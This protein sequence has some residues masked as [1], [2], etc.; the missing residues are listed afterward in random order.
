MKRINLLDASLEELN[1][2]RASVDREW[3]DLNDRILNTNSLS[4]EIDTMI[5]RVEQL[6]E[7]SGLLTLAIESFNDVHTSGTPGQDGGWYW[8]GESSTIDF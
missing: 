4:P 2:E 1:A 8:D 7:Y 3:A 6:S 5:A